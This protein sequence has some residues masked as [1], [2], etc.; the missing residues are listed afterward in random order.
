MSLLTWMNC[1]F[2][3]NSWRYS[4]I[5]I[6]G[7]D[8]VETM[9]SRL[10][11]LALFQPFSSVAMNFVAPIF[12]ASSF[13]EFVLEMATTSSQPRA[14]AHRSPKCPRPPTPT[15]PTL[16]PGPAPFFTRGLQ[17]VTPP[18]IIGAASA[19]EI[20]AGIGTAK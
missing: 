11:E 1:P 2:V 19:E 13:L 6:L 9:R 5:G 15:I 12:I 8:T 17:T 16:F 20:S 3:L 4:A 14:F 18:H 10:R 7:L